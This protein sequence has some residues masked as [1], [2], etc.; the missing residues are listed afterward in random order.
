[1]DPLLLLG[2]LL[3][4]LTLILLCLCL[5][6]LRWLLLLLLLLLSLLLRAS[7]P[8]ALERNLRRS[9]RARYQITVHVLVDRDLW[10]LRGNGELA[11]KRSTGRFGV[12]I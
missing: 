5:C 8:M 2:R 12:A 1:L 10:G 3:L 9:S 4:W 7:Q 6:L 11:L